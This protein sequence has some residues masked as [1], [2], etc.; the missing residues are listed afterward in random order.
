MTLRRRRLLVSLAAT[1]LLIATG[2][3]CSSADDEAGQSNSELNGWRY[4]A[5]Y[6]ARIARTALR[7]DGHGSG[8]MCLAETQNS[9]E[10]AGVKP[11]PRLPGAADWDNWALRQ[12]DAQ[13]GTWGF[14]RQD[15]AV[16]DI[17]KGSIIAWRP[18]QCG[19]HRIYG[20]IEIAVGNGRACSDFCQTIRTNCGAPHVYVP[21]G[22]RKSCGPGHTKGAIDDKYQALGGC[23]SILGA[24]TTDELPTRDGVGAY[25]V[26]ERGV[27]YWTE[28]TGAF[29][30]HGAIRDK[31]KELAWENGVLGYPVTDEGP[32]ADG[33][34]RYNHFQQGSIYWQESTGAHEVHGAIHDKWKALGWEMSFLGYPVSD[35]NTKADG[36]A[37]SQFEHGAIFYNKKL[38]VAHEVHGKILEKY[39]ELKAEAG[40]LGYP[41]SDE[42][43]IPGG[44]KSDFENGSISYDSTTQQFTVDKK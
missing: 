32:S 37:S 25:N 3:G 42:Y 1:S 2:A 11:F 33:H 18:G 5:D 35:E 30:V 24:P 44:R 23:D 43:D 38:D 8:D 28:A 9:L 20:H 41:L 16:T 40:E 22:F 39:T 6:G 14:Q 27:I 7:V 4:D 15:R 26:F 19:Y 21:V 10:R 17:P 31:W 34:G 29:E 36:S 12:S 13:L